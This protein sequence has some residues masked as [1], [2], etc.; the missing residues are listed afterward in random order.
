MRTRIFRALTPRRHAAVLG[1]VVLSA[2]RARGEPA[3]PAAPIRCGAH[4]A[5]ATVSLEYDDRILGD[6][7]GLFLNVAYPKTV[8]LPGPAVRDRVASLLESKF[9]VVPALQDDRLR[10]LV[11]TSDQ[12]GVPSRPTARIRFDCEPGAPLAASDF[13]CTT[14]QVADNSGQLMAPRLASQVTCGVTLAEGGQGPPPGG[15]QTH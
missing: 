4:G 9:R 11:T 13:R 8:S 5:E 6:V 12:S 3:P 10:L 1:I 7:T 15:G 14:E 2:R